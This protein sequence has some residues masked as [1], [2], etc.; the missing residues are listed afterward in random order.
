MNL[1]WLERMKADKPGALWALSF[2]DLMA[3]LL[4][5]FVM[6]AAMSELR[7]GARFDAVGHGV[8]SAF[9]FARGETWKGGMDDPAGCSSVVE[10]LARSGLRSSATSGRDISDQ[11]LL[12]P[13]EVLTEG[14]RLVI[15][16][17]G[18]A[19]FEP[20]SARL[21]PRAE[22]ALTRLA[23]FLVGGRSRLEI[24]G[25]GSD[26]RLPAE[27][28]FRDSLDLSYARARAVADLLVSSGLA[29]ER[30]CVT[31]QGDQEPVIRPEEGVS[32]GANRRIEIIVHAAPA[33][34]HVR[35]IAEKEHT[36]NG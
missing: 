12:S 30:L 19:S 13:C 11:E 20:F 24:R 35:A 36:E 32:P 18:E 17:A 15:R 27:A 34:E 16:I 9:G 3:L 33:A 31:A 1:F 25:H 7:K 6:I 5:V 8:R 2:G 10:R 4:A 26:G 29:R 14:D 21:A 22:A 28:P 23:D